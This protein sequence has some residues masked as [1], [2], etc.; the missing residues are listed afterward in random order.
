M[1]ERTSERAD[2]RTKKKRVW[3]AFCSS[4]FL[5][6]S[7]YP[8][9]PVTNEAPWLLVGY[10]AFWSQISRGR[11]W[12]NCGAK[13][14]Y[15]LTSRWKFAVELRRTVL[16]V[17]EA[18]EP[19]FARYN[20]TVACAV[21]AWACCVFGTGVRVQPEPVGARRDGGDRGGPAH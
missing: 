21:L 1:N 17:R 2:K 16:Y 18:T 3:R 7:L 11:K 20:I 12:R 13:L 15:K 10:A 19:T 4:P 14:S 8:C 9:V 5:Q 6:R